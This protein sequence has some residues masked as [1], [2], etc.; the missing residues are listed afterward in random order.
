MFFPLLHIVLHG[1]VPGIVARLA[2][3]KIW[4]QAWLVMLLTMLVDL[5]HLVASPIYDPERCGINFHPLHSYPAIMAY[6]LLL[7]LPKARII[8]LGLLVHMGLDIVDCLL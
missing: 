4:L 5:D 8:G 3:Q 1:L 6:F 7:F 2:F